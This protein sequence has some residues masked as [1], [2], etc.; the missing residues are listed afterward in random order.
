[1]GYI[2]EK[3]I[4]NLRKLYVKWLEERVI[5]IWGFCKPITWWLHVIKACWCSRLMVRGKLFI[6]RVMVGA[7]PL[8]D[9]LKK[10]T[11]LKDHV[12]FVRWNWNIVGIDFFHIDGKDGLEVYQFS[13]DV[14]SWSKHV[15]IRLGFCTYGEQRIDASFPN[16]FRVPEVGGYG[17]IEICGMPSLLIR[18][19][20]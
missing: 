8:G 10:E 7:L 2:I 19:L 11:L 13:V 1:M 4:D 6:W 3:M 15:F 5:K 16:Y 9:A 12:S 14:S 18:K 17:S 20:G